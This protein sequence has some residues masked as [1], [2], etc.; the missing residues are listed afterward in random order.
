MRR[1]EIGEL[2]LPKSTV[3]RKRSKK[4]KISISPDNTGGE[5]SKEKNV[6]DGGCVM[7]QVKIEQKLIKDKTKQMKF[8]K[9]QSQQNSLSKPSTDRK[10]KELDPFKSKVNKLCQI[11]LNSLVF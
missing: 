6:K 7:T 9:N 11:D 2:D 5:E 4:K 1:N 10:L 8:R 3:K